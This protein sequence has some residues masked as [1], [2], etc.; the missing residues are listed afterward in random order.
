MKSNIVLF[1]V[2]CLQFIVKAQTWCPVGTVWYYGYNGFSSAQYYKIEY[3]T[4]TV[5]NSVNCKKLKKTL[6]S[7]YYS[8]GTFDTVSLENEYTYSDLDKVYIFR[9][10]NFY[11]LYDFSANVGDSWEV[12]GT[13]LYSASNCDSVGSIKV[14]SIGTMFINGQNLRY[15]C[16]SPTLNSKWGWAGRIA[17]K[18]GPIYN[19][20][21]NI[22]PY[23]YLFPN[24]LDYCGMSI[25]D[26]H[27]GGFLRCY[28][29]SSFG[30]YSTGI[31]PD[32]EFLATDV[33]E[34][35]ANVLEFMI[36]PN[37]FYNESVIKYS[38]VDNYDKAEII[39]YNSLGHKFQLIQ[40]LQKENV[41]TINRNN[42]KSGIYNC[43][44]FIDERPVVQKKMIIL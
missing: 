10:N 36:A 33:K 26:L 4:D 30:L 22:E 17:E 6:Y 25:E 20:Q 27:E 2:L 32:C 37:P 24:K 44:L 41:V 42:L 38:I 11:V 1:F 15:I 7:Y 29:D 18:I 14:D 31:V 39:I 8:S 19:Y 34:N 43:V 3:D 35:R 9:F 16:V 23:N 5:I 40:L 13:N 28:Y 21:N 12:A